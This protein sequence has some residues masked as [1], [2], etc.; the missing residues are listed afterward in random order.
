MDRQLGLLHLYTEQGF[1]GALINMIRPASTWNQSQY[2]LLDEVD[3]DYNDELD[4]SILDPNTKALVYQGPLTSSRY[5]THK[6][7]KDTCK[8]Y[9]GFSFVPNEISFD[10]WILYC[11]NEYHIFYVFT[12]KVQTAFRDLQEERCTE[13]SKKSN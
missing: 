8:N 11:R 2:S 6:F 5:I 1:E 10:D 4:V 7:Y 9:G 13:A 3:L 12:K